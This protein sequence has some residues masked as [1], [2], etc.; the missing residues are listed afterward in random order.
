MKF[1]RLGSIVL[2]GIILSS[3]FSGCKKEYDSKNDSDVKI[4]TISETEELKVLE[5]NDKTTTVVTEENGPSA[6]TE[7]TTEHISPTETVSSTLGT[8]LSEIH[9][10]LDRDATN[11]Y[12]ADLSEFIQK[13]DVVNSFTFVFYSEDGISDMVNYKGG[14]GIS[15]SEDCESATDKGWYQSPDFEQSVNGAYA[16]ITWEVPSDISS[17]V[18]ASGEVLIGYWWSEVQKVEL[19]SIICNYTRT[20][21]V[22]V[23]G[24]SVYEDE[25]VLK[26][27]SEDEKTAKIA[28]S[29]LVGKD[30]TIQ[31]VTFDFH[32]DSA[33]K[34][35]NGAFG[36]SLKEGCKAETDK[37]WYQSKDISVITDDSNISLKWILP[38]E[39][40]PYIDLKGDIML[41][42]WWSEQSSLTLDK[43]TVRYSNG[44][45]VISDIISESPKSE[46]V[47]KKENKSV[48]SEEVNAM[49]SSE[50]IADMKI[51]W[52]LGN[53][54]DSYDTSSSDTETGWGN[55]K[56]TKSMIDTVKDAGFNAVRIPVTWS[57]HMSDDYTIESSWMSR[58]K[59]VVDYAID[60]DL[61]VI[62][63]VHH[64]DYIW[65]KPVYSE[66]EKAGEKLSAIWKQISETFRDYDHHLVFEGMNEPRV[67]GSETE[68]TGGTDEEHEVINN[69]FQ[70]F[71]DTVRASGGN[72]K[73]RTLII[74]SHAQ[75]ITE[76][77]VSA[78]KIPDDDHIAVSIHSY[79]PWDFCDPDNDRATWGS[80]A[81]K[82]E[83]DKNFK[84]LHDTFI[85][86]GIPVII[87]EFGAVNKN[88]TDDRTEYYSYYIKSAKEHDI[89]CFIW[90][91][92]D[93][94][95]GFG[96]L[97]RT[98]N[99]WYYPSIIKEIMLNIE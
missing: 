90:D 21:E 46:D 58:V 14:C 33:F 70:I 61:Y 27:E 30:D 92:G 43:V 76:T 78:V 24:T 97:N 2:A 36:I 38:D 34:K 9:A 4:T 52:N 44:T 26:Y 12:K 7:A 71:I 54:L 25:Q 77:A 91:N 81:D 66:Q 1:K 49:T 60:N 96:L 11:T 74:T 94:K 63:N 83:L 5:A 32:S 16:E 39:I 15:V 82:A 28:V 98:D 47:D 93:E 20:V 37:K 6:E 64:D 13:G 31:T 89:T 22:P 17:Y 75:S 72:N 19:R 23:D 8:E 10:I 86:K 3:L 59:E 56:T 53:T 55:P 48:S 87:G 88:N 62:L 85:S 50:I 84:Y 57:E 51:G 42:F 18:D 79:A 95:T 65:L 68:W 69:L 35:F 73:D 40:K 45:G 67:I 29:D 41:G 99:S 80:D